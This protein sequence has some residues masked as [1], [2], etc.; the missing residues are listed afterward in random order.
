MS[1]NEGSDDMREGIARTSY[2]LPA[3]DGSVEVTGRV[4][5]F[6]KVR[7]YGFVV[8]DDGGGDVLVHFSALKPHGRRALAEG[9]TVV[10]R[11]S[12]RARGLQCTEIISIDNSTATGPD[13]DAPQEPRERRD[14]HLL[15]DAGDPEPCQV[16]WFNRLKGYGFLT[17]GDGSPDIFLHMETARRGGLLQ[18]E[19]GQPLTVRI[20]DGE[21]G[22]LAVEICMGEESDDTGL[23]I[24][25]G[26]DKD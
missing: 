23:R 19:P 15:E 20:A 16:K 6:D 25:G 1:Q 2:A 21:R 18:L 24:V 11:A 12:E 10:C 14:E 13:P 3:R 26:T 22:P 4:K 9:A 5:W 17:R 7:G 8:P